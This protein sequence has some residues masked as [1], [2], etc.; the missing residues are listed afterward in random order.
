VSEKEA[1]EN[2]EDGDDVAELLD[3]AEVPATAAAAPVEAVASGPQGMPGSASDREESVDA[4]PVEHART[5]LQKMAPKKAPPKAGR[6]LGKYNVR[7]PESALEQ[8]IA[9]GIDPGD[10]GA[11]AP[12]ELF[13]VAKGGRAMIG[14]RLCTISQNARITRL[15]HDLESLKQQGIELELVGRS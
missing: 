4:A 11:I 8:V 6:D 10:V 9:R 2:T 1:G 15:T 14:G 5:D 7:G 12:V 3:G 13:R